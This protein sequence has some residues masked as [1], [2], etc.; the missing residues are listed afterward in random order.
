L[1]H[2]DLKPENILLV[3]DR[4]WRVDR[5]EHLPLQVNITNDKVKYKKKRDGSV[6][7]SY[8]SR[9]S[10]KLITEPFKVPYCR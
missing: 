1:V 3:K 8:S 10:E 9:E 5:V 6:S 7:F 2:T 4:A